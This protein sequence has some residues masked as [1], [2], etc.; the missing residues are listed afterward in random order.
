MGGILISTV[1]VIIFYY[2]VSYFIFVLF[3]MAKATGVWGVL[4]KYQ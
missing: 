1:L 2:T 4:L 3:V